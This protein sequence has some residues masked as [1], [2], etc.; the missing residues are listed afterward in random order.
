MKNFLGIA[1]L[2]ILVAQASASQWVALDT[3]SN[4]PAGKSL[5]R[6]SGNETIIDV[7]VPAFG[8]VDREINGEKYAELFI[9]ESSLLLRKG[10]PEL[11]KVTSFVALPNCTGATCSIVSSDFVEREIAPLAPSKGSLMRNID[12]DSVPFEF[13]AAY[14]SEGWYPA[15]KDLVSISEPFVM[16]DIQGVRVSVIPF[17]YNHQEKKLRIYKNIRISVNAAG[18]SKGFSRSIPV[19]SEFENLYADM[20]INYGRS[21]LSK[22]AINAPE[23]K[24]N[25]LIITGDDFVD[26]VK[27]LADWKKKS[28]YDVTVT[29]VSEAGGTAEKIK[30]Y[31]QKLYTDG[32][33]CFVL[34]VG[35]S[36]Q[37]PTLKGK[38]EQADSDPC[39]VKLAGDDNV[40]DAFIS[41]ISA[42]TKEQV[43]YIVMKSIN[44]EQ[45]PSQGADGA[46]YKQG[47]A[48]ASNQAGSDGIKD[49]ERANDINAT[50]KSKCGFTKISEC[51]EAE[52]SND[53]GGGY[54]PYP[55]DPWD[56]WNMPPMM[57]KSATTG[58]AHSDDKQVIFDAVNEGVS[59]INYI[60]H[61]SQ[62]SWVTSGF[63]V[64]D[65]AKLN[66]GMKLPVIWSVACVNG[67]FVGATCFAEAWLRSG[68]KDK[69]A[70]C[71][72]I[73]AASTNMAWI[74][75]CVWQKHIAVTEMGEK[76]HDIAGVQHLYGILKCMEEY[77]VDDSSDGNQLSEQ[78]H[79]FGDGTVALR[80]GTPRAVVKARSKT[81]ACAGSFVNVTG[82]DLT[83]V[84][85]TF[86]NEDL[87]DAVTVTP[88]YEGTARPHGF[89]KF[90]T[91]SGPN[92]VPIID[93]EIQ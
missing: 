24:K 59:V 78:T 86:Y 20:F 63:D 21:S 73:A 9:P 88:D 6:A 15:D 40:M 47:L 80:F 60:G 50:L 70:G 52:T 29:K 74:P 11:R 44:Y 79:Y 38:N 62:D 67:D 92:I 14:S 10:Q 51:Y 85:V 13:G 2:L 90:Y 82:A 39:Y 19:S 25:L 36:E 89:Y 71:V 27:P 77:G 28:G 93:E 42:E 75:P 17:Q 68:N 54:D 91:V 16:R 37:V 8:I 7:N 12:P 48:I 34:L 55:Y 66:N 4:A 46:W 18:S 76:K 41:R 69:P 53:N 81:H 33:L 23:V 5:V 72:G 83:G 57:S 35:D 31:L 26:A 87:S 65:C 61:G 84:L 32:K 45:F 22:A 43:E 1:L 58:R 49:Y 3:R 56:P 30:E 64:N